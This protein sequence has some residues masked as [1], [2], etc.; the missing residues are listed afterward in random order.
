MRQS[1]SSACCAAGDS[2]RASKTT[3]QWVVVKAIPPADAGPVA[4]SEVTS[5]GAALTPVITVR[6]RA[7]SKPACNGTDLD[8]R[9]GDPTP[10]RRENSRERHFVVD[11]LLK[12]VF[13]RGADFRSIAIDYPDL[14]T[15][16]E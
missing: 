16:L 3:L 15:L 12:N 2:P 10:L 13:N 9:R 7:E 1:L 14:L 11:G 5:S 8:R 6:S 4:L